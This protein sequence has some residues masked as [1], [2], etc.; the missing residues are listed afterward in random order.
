MTDGGDVNTRLDKVDGRRVP[1]RAVM[2]AFFRQG[3][4]F[5]RSHIK[6]FAQQVSNT[7]PGQRCA[8]VV[9]KAPLLG[10]TGRYQTKVKIRSFRIS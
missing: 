2:D 9:E 4:S 10:G 3:G 8:A 5:P 1:Q 7:E 6:M